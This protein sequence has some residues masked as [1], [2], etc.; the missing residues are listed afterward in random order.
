MDHALQMTAGKSY[1]QA[2][3]IMKL[4]WGREV[5]FKKLFMSHNEESKRLEQI[6]WVRINSRINAFWNWAV[7]VHPG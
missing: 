4:N 1:L 5:L 2:P 3:E 6:P 7:S